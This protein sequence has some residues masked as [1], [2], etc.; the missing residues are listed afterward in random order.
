MATSF[1]DARS[2]I[3]EKAHTLGIERV[4]LTEA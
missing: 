3:L 1:T 4:P 2:I